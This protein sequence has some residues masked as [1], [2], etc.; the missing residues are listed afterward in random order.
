MWLLLACVTT[1]LFCLFTACQEEL[2]EQNIQQWSKDCLT[3]LNDLH[4]VAEMTVEKGGDFTRY[5]HVEERYLAPNKTRVDLVNKKNRAEHQIFIYSDDQLRIYHS[6][7]EEQYCIEDPKLSDKLSFL[8]LDIVSNLSAGT[9]SPTVTDIDDGY[10]L[11]IIQQKNGVEYIELHL[12]RDLQ[13]THLLF[14]FDETEP[15]LSL[16]YKEFNWNESLV[17]EKDFQEAVFDLVF[18]KKNED[19]CDIT[20]Q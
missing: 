13:P 6:G 7:L 11:E 4:L 19:E 8:Y 10:K 17:T 12:D 9:V 16:T 3:E 5:Y 14:Y 20:L 2:T 15:F 1:S 18:Q